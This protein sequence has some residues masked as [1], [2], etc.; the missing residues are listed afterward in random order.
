[1]GEVNILLV[2]WSRRN[3]ERLL[4]G[5]VVELGSADSNRL[6][7]LFLRRRK[8]GTNDVGGGRR[9]VVDVIRLSIWF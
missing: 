5:E 1:L 7:R 9:V 3:G 6:N 4:G 2:G 8:N